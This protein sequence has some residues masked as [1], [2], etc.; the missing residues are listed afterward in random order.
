MSRCH[1]GP[2]LNTWS[3]RLQVTWDLKRGWVTH[4]ALQP[5]P[6][7]LSLDPN[8]PRVMPDHQIGV[9]TSAS[10]CH[11]AAPGPAPWPLG[12]RWAGSRNQKGKWAHTV[13]VTRSSEALETS[14]LPLTHFP[15]VPWGQWNLCSPSPHPASFW[16]EEDLCCCLICPLAVGSVSRSLSPTPGLRGCCQHELVSN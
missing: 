8:Y 14:L 5:A 2:S 3:I 13:P 1:R 15:R 9:G 11:L 6:S 4:A 10:L 7:D 12:K 16:E